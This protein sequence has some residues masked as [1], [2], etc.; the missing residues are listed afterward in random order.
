MA[1]RCGAVRV[2]DRD[3]GRRFRAQFEGST[4]VAE[5]TYRMGDRT[6]VQRF[7][8]VDMDDETL[9]VEAEQVGLVITHALDERRTWVALEASKS[10]RP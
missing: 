9:A 2:E 1:D 8:A 10:H 6:W 5:M 7:G 3:R 4:L